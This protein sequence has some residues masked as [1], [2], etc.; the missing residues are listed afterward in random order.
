[1]TCTRVF[2][3]VN[4][5]IVPTLAGEWI[6]HSYGNFA[7]RGSSVLNYQERSR[8]SYGEYDSPKRDRERQGT[9]FCER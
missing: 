6:L 9:C 7:Y 1:M 5:S 3:H 2:H 8:K 4:H